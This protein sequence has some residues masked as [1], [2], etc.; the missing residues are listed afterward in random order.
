[1][2]WKLS[3]EQEAYREALRD[4]LAAV[5]PSG[6]VRAWQAAGD[7]VTFQDR[8]TRDGMAGVGIA[9]EVG[10]Q[11]GGVVELALTAEELARAAA[12]SAAWLATVLA[13]PALPPDLVEG[14]LAGGPVA[15]LAPAEE[16]PVSAP[17]VGMDADGRLSGTVPRVLGGDVATA[18]V[19]VVGV[20]EDRALR[21][22]QVA[23]GG[24]EVVPRQLLDRS[25]SVADVHLRDAAS[26]PLTADAAGFLARATDLAGVLVAADSLGAM[27]RMLDLAVEYSG[28]RVQFG[29]PI[30]S[31]QAVKHAAAT[32]LVGVEAGRSGIYLAAASL[33]AGDPERAL[34]A[35][36]VKAQVTAE[37]SRAADTALTVHGAIGYTWEH[38]LQLFYKRARL[39]EHLFGAPVAWNERLADALALV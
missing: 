18:F 26:L 3:E 16:L 8:F 31:F 11:G 36:A 24:V 9:E 5:A 2:E 6:T 1:M 10:G 34:H 15:L 7:A 25:R 30:G 14:A 22:V 38:D 32:M 17:A 4:W 35:A 23:G 33:D 19:A 28:Q 12:P 37:G 27:E 39:D 13:L 20:G 21:L 29:V